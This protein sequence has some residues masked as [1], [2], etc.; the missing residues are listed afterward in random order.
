M[1]LFGLNPDD[2]PYQQLSSVSV[3]DVDL[4]LLV[5]IIR[6]ADAIAGPTSLKPYN[7]E[8]GQ[9]QAVIADILDAGHGQYDDRVL[10]A[11]RDVEEGVYG[12][13]ETWTDA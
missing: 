5:D 11:L 6:V 8:P 1:Q 13:F 3:G 12:V 7:L 4:P 2:D 10:A 9:A